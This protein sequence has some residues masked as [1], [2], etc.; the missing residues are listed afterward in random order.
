MT[1]ISERL[2]PRTKLRRRLAAAIALGVA[3][4][5]SGALYTVAMPAPQTATAAPDEAKLAEGKKLYEISCISCHG[6]NAEGVQGRGPSL[7]GVGEAAAYFQ[8]HSG[9]MPAAGQAAQM[10]R[11][12]PLYSD[13]EMD[14]L[15]AYVASFGDGPKMPAERGA[16]LNGNNPARGGELYRQNCGSCHGA[17]AQGGALS[18]GK[19]APKLEGVP[20]EDIYAA[21]LSGPENM[22]KFGDRQLTPEE[23]KDI[24]A[25]IN[26]VREGANDAGGSGLGGF[27][28]ASEGLIAF[29]V[30]LGALIGITMWI[31]SRA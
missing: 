23:K 15:V 8:L 13:K 29:L 6:A 16:A 2:R 5:G 26:T 31:G 1:T 21:L 12:P 28:P 10:E 14:A 3:L 7:I 4:L 11:K 17:N 18:S 24:I 19:F 22:P 30:G 20:N 27:G 9:R 25:Y